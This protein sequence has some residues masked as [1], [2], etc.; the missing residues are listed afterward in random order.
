MEETLEKKMATVSDLA[1]AVGVSHESDDEFVRTWL[2]DLVLRERL[3][4]MRYAKWQTKKRIADL[5]HDA[6]L[7]AAVGLWRERAVIT[8]RGLVAEVVVE[9]D[10]D[11]HAYVYAERFSAGDFEA[12]VAQLRGWLEP[13]DPPREDRVRIGFRYMAENGPRYYGRKI[14]APYWR[15]IEGNYAEAV[16]RQVAVLV[17]DFKPGE[18]GRLVLLHGD[19]GTGK[20]YVIRA[21]A[22]EW[23]EWCRV[24]YIADPETFL[25]DANYMMRVLMSG[26]ADGDD[27]GEEGSANGWRLLVLEDAGEL[28]ARDAKMW[29]GQG[30]S[31]LLN[32]SE[33]L[34]GQ[35]LR[36]LMLIS[37][38]EPLDALND[39]VSRPGRTAAVIEFAALN[40][41]E[42]K[43]WLEAHGKA[44]APVEGPMTLAEL[45]AVLSG[46][47]PVKTKRKN[48]IGFKGGNTWQS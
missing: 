13:K 10:D 17:G 30:L 28:L 18:G 41:D 12:A 3:T 26:G 48:P 21:L 39:A 36:V 5:P 42:A 47:P 8:V 37:T 4:F 22:R 20:T 35:G 19:P 40:A 33:G 11:C 6:L 44:E 15:E 46:A 34:I 43:A 32:M 31:R 27:D 14:E 7:C 2:A 24:E 1:P 23:R 45:Y 38:N 9:S 16:A 29:Q 25:R